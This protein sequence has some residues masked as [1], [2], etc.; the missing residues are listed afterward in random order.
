MYHRGLADVDDTHP[1]FHPLIVHRP[2]LSLCITLA[3]LMIRHTRHHLHRALG[4]LELDD[5]LKGLVITVRKRRKVLRKRMA[6]ARS[7]CI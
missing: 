3:S 5:R 4:L 1:A 6:G 7:T 2:P